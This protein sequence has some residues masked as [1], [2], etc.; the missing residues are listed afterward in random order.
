MER[1]QWFIKDAKK[2]LFKNNRWLF[3]EIYGFD[4]EKVYEDL[5]INYNTLNKVSKMQE[6][7]SNKRRR[8]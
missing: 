3:C 8:Y 1:N 4:L 6:G 7:E 2:L 5:G